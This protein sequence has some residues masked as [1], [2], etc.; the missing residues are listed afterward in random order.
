MGSFLY[1]YTHSSR[2][3]R[4][5]FLQ[6]LFLRQLLERIPS[7]HYSTDINNYLFHL[8]L[9]QTPLMWLPTS[10][11]SFCLS[12]VIQMIFLSDSYDLIIT[13]L[14]RIQGL[15]RILRRS[16][17]SFKMVFEAIGHPVLSSLW[18]VLIAPFNVF[19]LGTPNYSLF[20]YLSL[21]FHIL[22][23]CFILY[24]LSRCSF[25]QPSPERILLVPVQDPTQMVAISVPL[26]QN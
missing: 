7:K 11:L 3:V 18:T 13:I 25:S 6:T 2:F 12:P 19:I 14:K 23:T 5:Q 21:H 24:F 15:P 10:G 16:L 20:S 4:Y 9:L 26:T 8:E 17:H 22:T 1:A